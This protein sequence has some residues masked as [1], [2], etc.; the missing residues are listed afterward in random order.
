MTRNHRILFGFTLAAMLWLHGAQSRAADEVTFFGNRAEGKWMIGVKAAVV[1]NGTTGFDDSSNIGLL[2]GYEFA[3]PIGFDGTASIE[4][5]GSTN[6]SDGDIDPD[7]L[8]GTGG[9]WDVDTLAL[10]FAYRTPG[11]VFFKGKL[12]VIRSEVTANVA[13][14]SIEDDDAALSWGVGLGLRLHERFNAELE[15]TDDTGDTDIS[16]ISLG[17]NLLF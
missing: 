17:G 16:L 4:I 7:S 10:Y 13:G 11:T 14:Q 12:G 2:L 1:Q 8:F 9:D 3:R 5:E 15:F 6:L